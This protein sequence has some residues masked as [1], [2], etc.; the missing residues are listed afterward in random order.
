MTYRP[1]I[2]DALDTLAALVA[3][4]EGITTAQ[5]HELRDLTG[6]ILPAVETFDVVGEVNAVRVILHRAIANRNARE[7][8]AQLALPSEWPAAD[9][10]REGG[11]AGQ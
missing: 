11:E 2:D 4:A 3:G 8:L 7:R 9:L 1:T 5:L 6:D 10:L